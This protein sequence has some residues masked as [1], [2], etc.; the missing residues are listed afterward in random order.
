MTDT[1]EKAT[2]SAEELGISPP[3]LAIEERPPAPTRGVPIML[4]RL[5]HIRFPLGIVRRIREE[6]GDDAL[7][8][9]IPVHQ[10]S[11]LLHYAL[12]HEDPSMT[13]DKAE[14]L[15]DLE[16]MKEVTYAIVKATG[17]DPKELEGPQEPVSEQEASEA[18][19]TGEQPQSEPTSTT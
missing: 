12:L 7:T 11:K 1:V 17:R 15:V 18:T 8:E 13:P 14:M 6:L 19:E 5:R 3:T 10:I 2:D 4:D 9:G 16:N